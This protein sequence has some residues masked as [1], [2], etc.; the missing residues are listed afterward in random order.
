MKK[1]QAEPGRA[2]K[3]ES[4]TDGSYTVTEIDTSPYLRWVGNGRVILNNKGKP[5]MQYEPYFS[6]THHYESAPELVEIGV[7][8]VMFYDPVGR[9]VRTD[10]PDGT[11]S[12]VEFD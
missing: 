7:T 12:R 6:V 10:L 3:G 1:V 4:Q 2:K 11:F 5:G 8:P 9:L